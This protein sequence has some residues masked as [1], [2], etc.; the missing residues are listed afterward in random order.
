[1]ESLKTWK[2]EN[3]RNWNRRQLC[4]F[5][6]IQD[7]RS[8]PPPRVQIDGVMRSNLRRSRCAG[9][10]VPVWVD[11][12]RAHFHQWQGMV[13]GHLAEATTG[14]LCLALAEQLPKSIATKFTR[15]VGFARIEI[16]T[17]ITKLMADAVVDFDVNP[18]P[19]VQLDENLIGA[20]GVE[21]WPHF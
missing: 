7:F 10:L 12:V 13:K 1:M 5:P 4:R 20:R 9:Q 3:L 8:S 21:V 11:T 14:Q 18:V 16:V 6:G 19:F 15:H 2:P 17:N